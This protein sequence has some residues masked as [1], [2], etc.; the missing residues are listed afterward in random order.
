MTT[1]VDA[2]RRALEMIEAG[3]PDDDWG[4]DRRDAQDHVATK[5]DAL[6]TFTL[7]ADVAER[8]EI[9]W[10]VV[11]WLLSD[12]LGLV[13]GRGGQMKTTLLLALVASLASG[14]RTF[15]KFEVV[16]EHVVCVVSGEDP[17][18]VIRN[19]VEAI[20]RGHG[21]DVDRVLVRVHVMA[22]A[23]VD[24]A[25]K[26]WPGHLI[27]QCRAIGATVIVFDPL[28]ELSSWAENDP[29]DRRRLV[30]T[31]RRIGVE[32]KA[33][34]IAAHHFR[35]ATDA[36]DKNDLMRGG[37]A[38]PNASRQTYAVEMNAD[39]ELAIECLKFSRA[40]KPAPFV[41]R[42]HIEVDPENEAIWDTARFEY[43]SQA[44]AKLDKAEVFVLEQVAGGARLTTTD[45]KK[46]A[47][48]TGISGA[49]IARALK[50]LEMR[51]MIDFEPGAKNGKLWG[52]V[53]GQAGQP[54]KLVAG[55]PECL[56][57]NHECDAAACPPPL[58]G[59]ASRHTVRGS[60]QSGGIFDDSTHPSNGNGLFEHRDGTQEFTPERIQ[61]MRAERER[62]EPLAGPRG[63]E[64]PARPLDV[65][66]PSADQEPGR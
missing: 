46:M 14:G 64:D 57:G 26:Q 16:G 31:L 48:G 41:L 38:L 34:V 17:E 9:N 12:E 24:L 13:A 47:V 32:S 56:P 60:G 1:R 23:G 36:A 52:L 28:A 2:E 10:L 45:L 15:G 66:G 37:N 65:R 18:G 62:R 4:R 39:G 40:M 59:K 21:Y 7:L 8:P 58:G 11:G 51:R 35:K 19:R 44:T 27:E 6:P 22:L 20:C 53:A 43:V 3:E 49:D 50:L 63:G 5:Q 61:A 33:T 29:D 55:Q 42:P 54:E 25:D 30:Q